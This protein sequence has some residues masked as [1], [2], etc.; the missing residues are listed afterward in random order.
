MEGT[1]TDLPMQNP[2]GY[3]EVLQRCFLRPQ[4]LLTSQR[5]TSSHNESVHPDNDIQQPPVVCYTIQRLVVTFLRS[6][7]QR[8]GRRR[9]KLQTGERESGAR[10]PPQKSKRIQ[11]ETK[12]GHGMLLH[13]NRVMTPSPYEPIV[14]TR[15]KHSAVLDEPWSCP[16]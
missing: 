12:N 15:E 1:Y 3:L 11:N 9:P 8:D 2:D 13:N 10:R 4:I 16:L 5:R 7:I 6:T 14:S